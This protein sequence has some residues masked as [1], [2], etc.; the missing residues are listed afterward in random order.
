MV[1]KKFQPLLG[2]LC[3]NGGIKRSKQK[4]DTTPASDHEIDDAEKEGPIIIVSNA[5]IDPYAVMI[6][7]EDASVALGTVMASWWSIHVTFF[8]IGWR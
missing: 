8:A 2:Y 6:H 3:F 4:N 1:V 7:L 5:I